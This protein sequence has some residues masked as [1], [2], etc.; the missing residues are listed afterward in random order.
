MEAKAFPLLSCAH[1]AG[2]AFR[3]ALQNVTN[4]LSA[5]FLQKKEIQ[6][7]SRKKCRINIKLTEKISARR[8]LKRLTH[9]ERVESRLRQITFVSRLTVYF[10]LPASFTRRLLACHP[11][12][13]PIC[14]S[15][16]TVLVVA[17]AVPA[18]AAGRNVSLRSSGSRAALLSLFQG[19]GSG[20]D[21]GSQPT[22]SRANRRHPDVGYLSRDSI[23]LSCVGG[24]FQASSSSSGSSASSVQTPE[25]VVSFT[26][27]P[28]PERSA[29][30]PSP[31]PLPLQEPLAF[32][33]PVEQPLAVV[34]ASEPLSTVV[35]VRQTPGPLPIL[36]AG[37]ALGFSRKLR[38]RIRAARR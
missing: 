35:S 26:H 14:L 7:N 3:V 18:M 11:P 5:F 34:S 25:S 8:M 38:R 16:V 29:P 23:C 15:A 10:P 4:E 31:S 12:L 1:S 32:G 9:V 33:V 20:V 37:A 30:S 21:H 28:T 13:R 2:Q 6:S 24:A 36:G 27:Q 19:V 17:G 22:R